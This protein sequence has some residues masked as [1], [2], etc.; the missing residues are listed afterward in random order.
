MDGHSRRRFLRLT[1]RGAGLAVVGRSLGACS[2]GAGG[3][4]EGSEGAPL[5]ASVPD[6]PAN[7]VGTHFAHG[8]ASGDP[9]PGRAILWTRVTPDAPAPV[10]L[11][12]EVARDGDF[13]APTHAGVIATDAESDW[14]VKIDAIDLEPDTLYH[15]RFRTDRA[16]SATGRFRTLPVGEVERASLAVVSCSNY[17]AGFFH[18]YRDIAERDDLLAV[19]HLGD[20]LYEDGAGGY[21]T[22]NAARLGREFDPGNEGELLA[23]A[24]YRARHATYRRDADLQAMHAALPMIAVWDDHEIANNVWAGGADGHGADEG[25]F[26]ARRRAARRAWLEWL[27]VR[28]DARAEAP[29]L[30]RRFEIGT[31]VSIS[32]LDA[33]QHARDA[34]VARRDWIDPATGAF[35]RDGYARAVADPA[36]TML[37]EA[38]REWLVEG[39]RASGARWQLLGQ[40]VLMSEVAVPQEM[41]LDAERRY[42]P[43]LVAELAGLARRRRAGDPALDAASL[44]RLGATV[45]YYADGWLGYAAER[46]ALLDAAAELDLDL[47]VVGGD[48]HNAWAGRLEASDGRAVGAEYATTAVT[49]PGL[50][51]V[52]GVEGVEAAAA[53]EADLADLI[54]GVEYCNVR[55][56]GYLVVGFDAERAVGEWVLFDTVVSPDHSRSARGARFETRPGRVGRRPARV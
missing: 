33:R 13:A 30:F 1:A 23:L 47:V 3:G 38:Q 8:V 6:A 51:R 39:W 25:D 31:L 11:V 55:E 46:R 2:G 17:A 15:Y 10:R 32:M 40:Q 34:A 12:W 26:E 29:R 9:E 14:T 22:E 28:V 37:G 7:A 41:R 43:E 48:S 18:A 42:T 16:S 24:D 44:A 54:D 5:S 52:F 50:A 56:R 36:R 49:S 20:Y 53:L 21:A 27:P 45:P 4:G 35:D 19:L